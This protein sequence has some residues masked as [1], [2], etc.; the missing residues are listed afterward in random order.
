MTSYAAGW[1]PDQPHPGQ[2]R[3][4]DGEQWTHYVFSDQDDAGRSRWRRRKMPTF[5]PSAQLVDATYRMVFADRSMIVLLF[6]GSVLAALASAAILFPATHWAHITPTWSSDGVL[7]VLVAGLSY[8]AATFVIELVSGAVVGAAILRAEGRPATVR[9]A[10]RLAWGR[11]RQLLAWALVS[12]LVGAV[13]RMLERLGIGGLVAA[14]TLNLGWAFATIFA[15]PTIMVEGTMPV[16]TVRRSAGLLRR[17]FT[18]TLVSGI[19]L[20]LPWF[21]L[22]SLS[23]MAGLAGFITLAAGSGLLAVAVGALLVAIGA[24]GLCFVLAVSSALST[25]LEAFLYRYAV[26]LPVPGVDQHWLPPLHPA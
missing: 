10:L 5:K 8:G 26:G 24:V 22:G 17:Q 1:Y 3:Y 6:V 19:S 11:R 14:L 21:V 2:Q 7:G 12:T 15:M 25:Y 20:A 23:L 9:D 16:E 4:W 13:I 18:V